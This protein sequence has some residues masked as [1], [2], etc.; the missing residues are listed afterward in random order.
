MEVS[1]EALAQ[2]LWHAFLLGAVLG[3]IYD[4]FRITRLLAGAELPPVA[5]SLRGRLALPECLRLF[6][7]REDGKKRRRGRVLNGIVLF[8]E[9]ICFCLLAALLLILL[10]YEENDGQFRLGALIM[11]LLGF[12]VYLGTLGRLVL[13]LSGTLV[14]LI[15]AVLRFVGAVLLWPF[16]RIGRWIGKR[17]LPLRR[18]IGAGW[19][20]L[21]GKITG[22]TRTLRTRFAAKKKPPTP[23]EKAAGSRLT[24]VPK[25]F[26]AGGGRRVTRDTEK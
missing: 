18:A 22:F 24:G 15:G 2:L 6:P 3:F 21:K 13:S 9:D 14:A 19:Q 12:F 16:F 1:Q 10:L 8:I 23:P 11:M 5:G 25:V 17:T 4:F 7:R 20:K 26:S